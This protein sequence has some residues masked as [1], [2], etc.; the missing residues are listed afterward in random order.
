MSSVTINC[1]EFGETIKEIVGLMMPEK[2]S[3]IIDMLKVFSKLSICSDDNDNL[4]KL[5]SESSDEYK[6][7]IK[8]LVKECK[9]SICEGKDGKMT[10]TCDTIRILLEEEDDNSY[11]EIKNECQ[12]VRE[13]LADNKEILDIIS[14]L[15]TKETY[16]D[17]KGDN[18]ILEMM[19]NN[20]PDIQEESTPPNEP[21]LSPSLEGSNSRKIQVQGGVQD[22]DIL[23]IIDGLDKDEILKRLK[24]INKEKFKPIIQIIGL[25]MKCTC[26]IDIDKKGGLSTTVI[27]II[28]LAILLLLGIITYSFL[29][30]K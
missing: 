9:D 29:K 18:T 24:N 8:R 14:S 13:Q 30:S 22:D 28:V 11:E 7:E 27:I 1:N 23:E 4:D 21:K 12:K 15:I 26:D 20:L 16:V 5:F 10:I 19:N 25:M 17:I 3:T 6:K 2:K